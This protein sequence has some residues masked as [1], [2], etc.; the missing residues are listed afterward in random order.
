MGQDHVRCPLQCFIVAA[1][2][3]IA[4]LGGTQHRARFRQ[5]VLCRFQ[6][7]VVLIFEDDIDADD[8]V[9]QGVKPGE[10]G[11]V[12]DQLQQLSRR[13]DAPVDAFIGD[14]FG[15]DEGLVQAKQ[16]VAEVLE[17][18]AQ[19]VR[20]RIR[21]RPGRTCHIPPIL[22]D[23]Q[24]QATVVPTTGMTPDPG[25]MLRPSWILYRRVFARIESSVGG[26][27]HFFVRPRRRREDDQGFLLEAEALT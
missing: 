27:P 9:L 11:I 15:D 25:P 3:T 12:H 23:P 26:G 7:R 2:K 22:T 5:E 20:N 24:L 6:G 19:T 10:P 8:E 13:G 16:A 21:S 4:L 1:F 18:A 14:L 17:A